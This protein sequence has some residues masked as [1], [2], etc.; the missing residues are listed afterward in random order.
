[1]DSEQ[2]NLLVSHVRRACSE[3][4]L[5]LPR[6]ISAA[7]EGVNDFAL[8]QSD[9]ASKLAFVLSQVINQTKT[10]FP[11]FSRSEVLG[12]IE[13]WLGGTPWWDKQPENARKTGR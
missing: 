13:P 9:K 12:L 10:D 3:D 1:M 6:V 7:T 2:K 11:P 8:N 5:L 4:P